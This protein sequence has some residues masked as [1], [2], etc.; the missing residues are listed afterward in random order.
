MLPASQAR[1][2]CLA[3]GARR[4][5]R[6]FP[7]LAVAYHSRN[8]LDAGTLLRFQQGMTNANQTYLGRRMFSLFR[9]TAFRPV[10]KT[11]DQSLKDVLKLY[12][13]PAEPEPDEEAAKP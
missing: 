11:Y 8:G 5:R 2:V 9:M 1:P 3:E 7:A 13:A 12:P 4:N 10:P 6:R